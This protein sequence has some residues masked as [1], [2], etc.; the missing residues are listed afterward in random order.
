MK[1]M[2]DDKKRLYWSE[3]YKS[4]KEQKKQTRKK[5]LENK[6]FQKA[7]EQLEN[8]KII[9]ILSGYVWRN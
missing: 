4:H 7:Q 3:Y 2:T 8:K 9:S 5:W 6:T 1:K